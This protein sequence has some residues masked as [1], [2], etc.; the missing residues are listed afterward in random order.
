MHERLA[1]LVAPLLGLRIAAAPFAIPP[2]REMM[3]F[4]AT[5]AQDAGLLWLRERICALAQLV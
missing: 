2:M 1:R 3:Q 4:H 5:R